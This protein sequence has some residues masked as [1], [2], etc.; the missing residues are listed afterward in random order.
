MAHISGLVAADVVP[1]P[2]EHSDIVTTT[3]H[4]SLRGPRGAMIFYRKGVQKVDKKGNEIMY[5]LEG[6]I[7]QSVFPGLQGG[8]HNH[9]ISALATALK[10][11]ASPEFKAYQEK[12]LSNS[13]AFAKAMTSRGYSLVSGGTDNH[14]LLVDL[15]PSGIDGARRRPPRAPPSPPRLHRLHSLRR[16]LPLHRLHRLPHRPRSPLLS[17]RARRVGRREGEH[18][19]QQEHGPRRQVGLHPGRHPRRHAGAHVA[20]LR[21]GALR[22]GTPRAQLWRNSAQFCAILLRPLLRLQVAEFIHRGVQIAKEVNSSGIGKKLA[23]FK[24]ALNEKPHPAIEKLAAD[25]A[26]FAA[27][28]PCVGFDET[29]M[30]Y[31]DV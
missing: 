20:R 19:D 25:V 17:R 7:N 9:T 29:T 24:A 14:L 23:D 15:K 5:D 21:G 10:Q 26:A 31:K 1:T 3:T 27:Q 13:Q 6:P 18:G 4:K 11:A 12:V 30:K 28:F 8:P 16:L 22:R 2:F